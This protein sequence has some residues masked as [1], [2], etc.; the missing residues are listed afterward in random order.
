[1]FPGSNSTY[2]GVG[3][4]ES[5]LD[6]NDTPNDEEAWRTNIDTTLDWFIE[7][8]YHMIA[9]YFNEVAVHR[10]SDFTSLNL[11]LSYTAHSPRTHAY[12]RVHT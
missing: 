12:T 5:I 4:T 9:L 6:E 10:F 1:M 2:S 8:D 7:K 11:T 3:A